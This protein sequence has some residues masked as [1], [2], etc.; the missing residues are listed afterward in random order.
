MAIAINGRAV[1]REQIGGVERYAREMAA[2]LPLLAPDRYVVVRP[3]VQLAHRAGHGWEQL[4]LPVV[5]RGNSLLYSPANLAPVAYGR[6]A[7]VIHDVA[8][9]RHP[10]AYS[11]PYVAYQRWMLPRLARGARLVLTV[12]EFSKRELIE[13]L[14]VPAD[15]VAVVPGGVDERFHP[16]L[17]SAEVRDR[18]QLSRPYVL[19]LGTASARKNLSMLAPAAAQLAQ[20]GIELVLAGSD[21][22]YLRG[23]GPTV[24]RLGYVPEDDLPALYAGAEAFVMPSLY[25]GFGLPCLEAM[26]VGTPVVAAEIAALPEVC[27]G[28]ASLVAPGDPSATADALLAVISEPNVRRERV[29][30]GLARAAQYPWSRTASRTDEALAALLNR[31]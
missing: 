21:R 7:V 16:E 13:V 5:C 22:G 8:A 20:E 31:Y 25:E 17:D 1:V 4:V 18:H 10:E 26:A 19:A 30:A 3:P 6:N 2:R 28:A 24:R 14:G 12:S 11:R 27:G 23:A 9:L 29:Q 15:Q